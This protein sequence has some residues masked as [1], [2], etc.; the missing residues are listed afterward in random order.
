VGARQT[1]KSVVDDGGHRFNIVLPASWA[2]QLIERSLRSISGG[3]ST[4]RYHACLTSD[5]DVEVEIEKMESRKF[6]AHR[7]CGVSMLVGQLPGIVPFYECQVYSETTFLLRQAMGGGTL[8]DLLKQRKEA[9]EHV[10]QATEEGLTPFLVPLEES[11]PII[12]DLLRGV[13]SLAS[14]GVVH[15]D[16]VEDKVFL[17]E[18]RAYIGG[19]ESACV[20]G[21]ADL[22]CLAGELIGSAFRHAPE[23]IFGLPTG[24]SNGVW[25]LGLIF[26]A[27]L[28]GGSPA[29]TLVLREL[30][31][32]FTLG[33]DW[34]MPGREKIRAAVRDHF[35]IQEMGEFGRVSK[36]YADILALLVGMLGPDEN[37]RWSVL[38]SLQQAEKVAKARG[39]SVPVPIGPPNLPASWFEEW[40]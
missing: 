3:V 9:L 7:A 37:R 38:G 26:A 30:P 19:L 35:S 17:H 18:G 11:L 36:E 28:F 1:T 10:V 5:C 40:S 34:N 23:M 20:P 21:S 13:Q 32:T 33:L 8:A 29:D 24:P 12:I 22:G 4:G 27:M 25:S 39:I 6:Q 16:L 31:N 2:D 14:K 15:G